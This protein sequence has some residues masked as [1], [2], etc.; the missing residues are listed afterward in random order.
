MNLIFIEYFTINTTKF[1]LLLN[2]MITNT[3]AKLHEFTH[4]IAE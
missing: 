2:S 1:Y 3:I 4:I